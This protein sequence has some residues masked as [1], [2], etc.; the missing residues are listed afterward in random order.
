MSRRILVT[1]SEYG[2]WGEELVGP[3][4]AFDALGYRTTFMTPTGKRPQALP[5]SL[6]PSYVDPP[7][8]RTVTTRDM[9]Q[10]AG[11]LDA[12]EAGWTTRCH[13]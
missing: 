12:S 4:D 8:G 9:A 1:L 13:W 7:L 3:L 5:P 11:E 2:Y 6:D 10:R